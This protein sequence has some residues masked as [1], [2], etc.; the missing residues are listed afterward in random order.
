MPVAMLNRLFGSGGIVAYHDVTRAPFSP[1][2]HITADRLAEQLEFLVSER[3]RIIPLREFV[4]RRRAGRSVRRCVALT[5]DDAYHGVLEFALPVLERFA[6]PA[7]IFVA[8]AFA[9]GDQGGRYWWDRLGWVVS[10]SNGNLPA[11]WKVSSEQLRAQFITTNAGRL[12]DGAETA[13]AALEQV[14]GAVPVRSLTEAELHELARSGLIDFGC[15]TESHPALPLLSGDAQRREIRQSYT[16]LADRL[17]RV[18]EFLAY[19]YGLFDKST[20]LAARDAGMEAAFSIEG[21]AAGSRFDLYAC[22][23]IGMAEVNSLRSLRLHLSWLLIPLVVWRHGRSPVSTD[24]HP[25]LS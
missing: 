1:A 14:V 3:Y 4:E 15:H 22:P 19:P 9:R 13:L 25:A 24:A 11:S 8:T 2:M 17:P 10:R 5:F 6:A 16:W 20:V 21:R 7:T 12:E 23:R 18:H